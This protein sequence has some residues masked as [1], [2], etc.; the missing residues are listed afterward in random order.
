MAWPVLI[1]APV[2][3]LLHHLFRPS[4]K[5]A[6]RSRSL[7][8][9]IEEKGALPVEEVVA[10]VRDVARALAPYHAHGV[11]HG[12]L[13]A[14]QVE[15]RDEGVE[16]H[17]FGTAISTTTRTGTDVLRGTPHYLAPE[18]IVSGSATPAADLYAL[19]ALAYFA[20]TGR[21][22]FEGSNP[23]EICEGHLY[24]RP[25]SLTGAPEWFAWLV[26]A[27]LDKDPA[28]RPTA[29]ELTPRHAA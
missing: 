5:P 13:K 24:Q 4:I 10:L 12:D 7:E 1:R 14:S 23:I 9:R 16:L 3:A 21:H 25:P 15:M 8:Q 20:A 11:A 26:E 22:A 28:R 18:V 29:I 27:L 17:G 2:P 6:A 19:G